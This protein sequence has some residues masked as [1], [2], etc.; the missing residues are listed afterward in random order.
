MYSYGNFVNFV[1]H[2]FDRSSALFIYTK[3]T[4]THYRVTHFQLSDFVRQLLIDKCKFST[5]T[6]WFLYQN[7]M[8]F[9]ILGSFSPKKGQRGAQFS[10]KNVAKYF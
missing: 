6:K 3:Y 2:I 1:M 8:T 9:Y 4:N 10:F 5:N 7:I